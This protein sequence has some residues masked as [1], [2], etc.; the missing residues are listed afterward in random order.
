ME[1]DSSYL[2]HQIGPKIRELRKQ[3]DI[4]LLDLAESSGMSTAMMSKIENGRIIPTIPKLFNIINV[5]QIAPD[6]FFAGINSEQ[7]FKGY[8]VMRRKDYKHYVKEESAEGFVYE[9]IIERTI[10][11]NAFQISFVTLKPDNSRPKVTTAAYEY[12]YIISGEIEYHIG[13][14]KLMLYSGDSFFFDGTIP[15]VP[16]NILDTEASY[17]VVYLFND[18]LHNAEML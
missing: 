2:V 7:V 3:K 13:E 12:L 14:E 5:L 15:H 16:I 1:T 10:E 18:N 6:E 11:S 8:I 4:R 9:S 17:I